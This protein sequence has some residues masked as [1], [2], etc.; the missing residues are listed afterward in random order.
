MVVI[1]RL[2]IIRLNSDSI[3]ALSPLSGFLR[4]GQS[5][6][7]FSRMHSSMVSGPCRV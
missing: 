2:S 7:L 3:R 5:R 4:N 1:V 6:R